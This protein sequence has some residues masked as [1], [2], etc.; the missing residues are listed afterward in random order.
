MFPNVGEK[1]IITMTDII[2]L[3]END[4]WLPPF[5]AAFEAAGLKLKEWHLATGSIDLSAPPEHAIYYS[6]M[7]A[8]AHTRGHENAPALAQAMLNWLELHGRQ[9]FNGSRALYFETSKVAQY[10]ALE[11]IGIPTPVTVAAA[12][13]QALVDAAER[14]RR[15]PVIVKP[16]RGG[17]GLGVQRFEK[18]SDL[19]AFASNTKALADS[20]DGIWLL[21]ELFETTDGAIT[22]AEFIDGKFH[23]AVQV[24]TG[25]SF[26][27]CPAEACDIGDGPSFTITQDLPTR[28]MA[29]YERFLEVNHISIAGIEFART[30]DGRVLTYDINTNT[31]YNPAAELAAGVTPGPARLAAAIQKRLAL[32]IP[33]NAAAE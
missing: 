27:L 6:R 5:R 21:Q 32:D 30:V 18:L 12:G 11:A 24:A 10:T 7:S 3:H 17:K 4:E 2:I 29:S 25:G 14:F 19:Q 16:N 15:W 31:N 20:V 26:E 8:S 22:R 9:I 1:V 28:L 33:K 13:G 23:Y